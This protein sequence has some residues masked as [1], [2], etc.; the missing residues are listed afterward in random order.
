MYI[1]SKSIT[2]IWN[3]YPKD[4]SILFFE[5]IKNA[6]NLSINKIKHWGSGNIAVYT[7]LDICDTVYIAGFDYADHL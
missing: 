1:V 6:P 3:D 2:N 7:A 4:G 5:D